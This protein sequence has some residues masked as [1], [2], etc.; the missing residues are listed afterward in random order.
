MAPLLSPRKRG[1]IVAHVLDG[2]TYKEIAQKYS[3]AKGTVAYTMQRE[4]LHNTQKSLPTGRR[5]HKMTE[6]SKRWLAREIGLFP[7]SPW[8][9]F[10]KALGVSETT[11][12]RA[13]G[14]MGLHKRICRK[15]PFLSEKSQAARRTWAAANVDQDWRR[16][17]FTDECAIQIGKDINRYYTIRRP[18]QEYQAKHLQPTFR[19]GR[20]SLM[21]WGAIAYGKKWP[22]VRLPLSPQEVAADGLGKGKGLNSSRYI[23][24]VLEGPLKRC[25]R[26]QQRA[27][28]RDVVVLEDGAPCHSSKVTCAACQRLGITSIDHPPNSPDLNAIENMWHQLKLK[29]GRMNRRATSLD[30]L[31][32]QIQ[33]AWDELDI[34]KVNRLVD[35]MDERRQ[36]VV[37]A[38]GSYTRF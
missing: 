18:G 25:V 7:Q 14:S 22:L 17:I 28:W 13:A 6:R 11:V 34:G 1:K 4:R 35:S 15:K 19:S 27:R 2:K 9:Y 20:T 10:A 26:A 16:V 23:K 21:V 12:R 33:Q 5:P 29:L 37:A 38:R 8:D 30:E 3:I 31:W 32:G 36:D 24:Y